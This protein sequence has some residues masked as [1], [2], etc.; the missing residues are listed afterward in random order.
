MDTDKYLTLISETNNVHNFTVRFTDE[1]TFAED[2]EVAL[3]QAYLPHRDSH[4]Q[5]S[6]KKYFPKNEAIGEL[7]VHYNTSPTATSSTST[8]STVRIHDIVDGIIKGT[9]K[10]D[11]LKM[12]YSVARN[13]IM[14][15]LKTDASVTAAY[16]K[17][18]KGNVLHQ[19]L[20]ETAYGVTLKGYAVKGGRLTLDKTLAQMLDV[21]NVAGTGL[22]SGVR[23]VFRDNDNIKR[24]DTFT[25]DSDEINLFSGVDWVFT[26]LHTPWSIRY[27]PGTVYQHV[28]INCDMIIPQQAN[29]NKY[30]YTLHHA[31]VPDDDS[32]VIP[33]KRM[34][35]KLSSTSYSSAQIWIRHEPS[36]SDIVPTQPFE[37]TRVTLHFRK[38]PSQTI[39]SQTV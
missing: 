10:L 13:K 35:M 15:E 4:F 2:W 12:I 19:I 37:K 16:P 11:V 26:T 6:F 9:T 34:Y 38:K 29:N 14:H 32:L 30:K 22:G 21:M 7:A 24:A 36:I 1:L 23:F 25:Y 27:I 28:D 33:H 18:D 39:T 17:D 3:V 31:E 5:E 20:E 8:S